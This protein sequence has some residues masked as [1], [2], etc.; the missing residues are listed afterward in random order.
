MNTSFK[1]LK[2]Y[3]IGTDWI[4]TIRVN[5]HYFPFKTAMKFPVLVAYRTVLRHME[6]GVFIEGTITTGMLLFGYKGV[7]FIDAVYERTLWDVTGIV[8]IKGKRLDIGRGSKL[9]VYGKCY[10]GDKFS[11]SGRS[12]IICNKE[13]RF[14][15][16]VLLSWDVLIMDT[17]LH[18]IQDPDGNIINPEK[19]IVIGDNVWIGCRAT[20][21]KG[22]HIP[23]NS[24]IAASSVVSGKMEKENCI[25]SSN[26]RVIK[27]GIH[28]DK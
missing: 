11:I 7:G 8:T 18:R 26:R 14:G 4:K 27:D 28:W 17:D 22:S 10:L 13:I 1:K 19:A 23:S 15:D 6:G 24:V 5:F 16:N 21:L 20:I 3:L 25:Y 2:K 12:T 9:C